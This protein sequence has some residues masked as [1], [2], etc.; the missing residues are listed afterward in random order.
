MSKLADYIKVKKLQFYR[1]KI[2]EVVFW[3]SKPEEK[4]RDGSRDS[5]SV[6]PSP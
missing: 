3:V 2:T 5:K 6:E 1:W 4:Q